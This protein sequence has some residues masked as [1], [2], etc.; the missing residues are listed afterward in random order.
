M[1]EKSGLQ[2]YVARWWNY[3]LDPAQFMIWDLQI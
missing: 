2:K 3:G 1:K